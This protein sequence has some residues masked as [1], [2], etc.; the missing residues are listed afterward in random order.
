MRLNKQYHPSDSARALTALDKQTQYLCAHNCLNSGCNMAC[1]TCCFWWITEI[2]CYFLIDSQGKWCMGSLEK[3]SIVLLHSLHPLWRWLLLYSCCSTFRTSLKWFCLFSMDTK[4]GSLHRRDLDVNRLLK[5]LFRILPLCISC[6]RDNTSN[7]AM[8]VLA[9][10][11]I[12]IKNNLGMML[13][14]LIMPASICLIQ[15]G[16]LFDQG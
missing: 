16:M 5:K 13:H 3:S 14:L 6:T 10:K 2:I 15:L 4:T 9:S 8:L 1:E 12:G 7:I 11:I